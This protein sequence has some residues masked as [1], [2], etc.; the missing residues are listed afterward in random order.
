MKELGMGY[1]RYTL[2]DIDHGDAPIT[3]G[4]AVADLK[5]FEG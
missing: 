5:P 1:D 4:E 2:L 3:L